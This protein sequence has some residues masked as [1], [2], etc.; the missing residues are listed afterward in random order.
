MTPS[1]RSRPRST[2]SPPRCPTARCSSGRRCGAPTPRCRSG[3]SGSARSSLRH[4]LGVRRER[5]DL[6][7]WECG[8]SPVAILLSNCPEYV[9]TMIGAFRARAVPF[10]VNHHYNAAEVAQLLDQIGAEAV[11]YHRRLAPLLADAARRTAACSSTSTTAPRRRRCPAA[12]R[13]K[14]RSRTAAIGDALPTP[15]PD[16]LY[17]VC[18]GGTTGRPKGVLWRQA[19]VYVARD[20]RGRGRHGRRR[21]PRR[22]RSRRRSGSPRHRSCTAPRSGRCS[23]RCTTAARS[24]CTTTPRRSTRARSSRP[25]ERERVTLLDD[26]RRCVRAAD[27]RRAAARAATTSRRCSSSRRAAR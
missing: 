13:S 22:R 17:L 20:G 24:C 4:G 27:R 23:P 18:T 16:D 1:G 12:S 14:R 6:A 5:S 19:D 21:S 25:C 2:W 11:V 9:E 26:R 8:Q 10:N 3:R 7:R 15:S